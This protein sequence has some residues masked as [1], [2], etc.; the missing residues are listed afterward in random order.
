MSTELDLQSFAAA[1]N[2]RLAAQ[3][4]VAKAIAFGWTCAGIGC[5]AVLF[6]VGIVIAF[7]GYSQVGAFNR[8]ADQLASALTESFKRAEIKSIVS[9]NVAFQAGTE[10]SLA[11]NQTVKLS[12]D[13]LLKLEPNSPVRIVGDLKVDVP[14]P[15]KRQLQLET[16]SASKDVPFTRYTIF[17]YTRFGAGEVVTGWNFD[18]SDTNRPISQRC[19]YEENLRQGIAATQ[20]IG[21]NGQP[22]R[23]SALTK[24]TFDFDGALANCIWFSGT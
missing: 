17:K 3:S 23:P 6:G 7:I 20:T 18:L 13:S 9:G 15:S 14:Q 8:S 10:L 21:F 11:A 2:S 24:L 16:T 5:A 1:I 12:D 22:R 19:Y 4:R